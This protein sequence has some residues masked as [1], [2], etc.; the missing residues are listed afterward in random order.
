MAVPLRDGVYEHLVTKLLQGKLEGIAPS[1][2]ELVAIAPADLPA[3]LSRHLASE[4]ERVLRSEGDAEAQLALAH[5]VL[6]HLGDGRA[7]GA[8]DAEGVEDARLV[9]PAR[10]LRSLYRTT[11]P[12][13]PATSLSS[14]TLLTRTKGE[15]S[16]RHEAC[17]RGITGR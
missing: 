11:P 16:L 3:W 15:P 7:G 13:R 10:V 8:R 4:I 1:I 12:V 5:H 14:S 9:G 2:A 6:D 17:P